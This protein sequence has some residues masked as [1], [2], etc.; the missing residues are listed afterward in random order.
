MLTPQEVKDKRFV[1]A[2]FGGYDMATVDEFL[3]QL[4]EDYTALFKENTVLK[5][6]LKVLVDTVEEYRTVDESM[7][8]ALL[9]AQKIARDMV[10]EAKA[11]S[12]KLLESANKSA[13]SRRTEID[14]ELL[15][16]RRR[17]DGAKQQTQKFIDVMRAHFVR[18]IDLLE[19]LPKIEIE[20]PDRL[21][22]KIETET[23]EIE[24]NL[25]SSH[26]LDYG[27]DD[28]E[29]T[30]EFSAVRQEAEEFEA[31]YRASVN[32]DIAD[33]EQEIDSSEDTELD[34]LFEIKLPPSL[35]EL[36]DE[37]LVGEDT[38]EVDN[39]IDLDGLQFG[40]NYKVGK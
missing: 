27:S 32:E 31:E 5:N 7:R 17:L 33:P 18:Q 26:E 13:S 24:Q 36:P 1:K 10:E 16:E 19:Q 34:E 23:R 21:D 29:A 25:R 12:E 40:K 22:N 28:T 30:R 2:V 14:N 11:K 3:E 8:R 39:P 15:S 37:A 9:G 6:K 4:T 20:D 35:K 38:G